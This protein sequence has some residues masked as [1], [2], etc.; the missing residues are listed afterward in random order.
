[1]RWLNI[2]V[3]MLIAA[4]AA[5]TAQARGWWI[6]AAE[7]NVADPA[8]RV[9]TDARNDVTMKFPVEYIRDCRAVEYLNADMLLATINGQY[10]TVTR[11]LTDENPRVD[12]GD[13]GTGQNSSTLAA[14]FESLQRILRGNARSEIGTS[15]LRKGESLPGFPSGRIARI[16]QSIRVAVPGS[17]SI[18]KVVVREESGSRS[19]LFQSRPSGESLSIPM[20]SLRH[21]ETYR[22]I[23]HAGDGKYT[24][25]FTVA[26]QATTAE[27]RQA[28]KN[29]VRGLPDGGL[30]RVIEVAWFRLYGFN[31]NAEMTMRD[32]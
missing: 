23:A 19:T 4:L 31:I 5:N 24:D 29:A 21:G 14:N 16:G 25:L 32:M 15:K 10:Q 30:S 27:L 20:A 13:T 8:Y 22:W 26:D 6:K 3:T 7:G 2:G 1:M 17:A 18:Q 9:V 12:C 28:L 11:R